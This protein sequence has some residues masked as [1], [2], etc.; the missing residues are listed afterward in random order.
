VLPLFVAGFLIH[1]SRGLLLRDQDYALF[2]L[3]LGAGLGVPAMGLLLLI[4][5]GE[6]PLV[7]WGSLWQFMVMGLGSAL[8]APLWCRLFQLLHRLIDYEPLAGSAFRPDREIKRGR[9]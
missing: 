9:S 8:A 2:M 6:N 5:L 4:T 3:G 7:G 1:H